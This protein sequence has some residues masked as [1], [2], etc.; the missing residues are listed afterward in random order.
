MLEGSNVFG[1]FLYTIN[2]QPHI[3]L[4]SDDNCPK[5]NDHMFPHSLND[6]S[7]I[8]WYIPNDLIINRKHI[9]VKKIIINSE[10]SRLTF[11]WTFDFASIAL[12]LPCKNVI[13]M[14][15]LV[16]YELCV[17]VDVNHCGNQ[18]ICMYLASN[19]LL[20]ELWNK[21]WHNECVF[22]KRLVV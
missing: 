3:Q 19:S 22:S 9:F 14:A 13:M 16:A 15:V 20:V 4:Q 1:Q 17:C 10:M 11:L 12:N 18:S 5:H 2:L 21:G 8:C 7:H 6:R